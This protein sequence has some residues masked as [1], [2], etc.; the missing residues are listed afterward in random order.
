MTIRIIVN[1]NRQFTIDLYDADDRL[2]DKTKLS[3]GEKEILAISLIWALSRLAERDLPV[4]IDTPLGRL[5][6][7]HRTNIARNYFPNAGRQVILLSTNT[8]VVGEEYNAIKSALNKCFILKKDKQQE[9]SQILEG[10]FN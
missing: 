10:Y 3:A 8:E 7:I 5:D 6:T 4:V 2:L 9:S 1:P